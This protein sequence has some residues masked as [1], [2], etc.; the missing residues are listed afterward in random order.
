MLNVEKFFEL[1]TMTW[2]QMYLQFQVGLLKQSDIYL[3]RM[4]RV[5]RWIEIREIRW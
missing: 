5:K 1:L 3:K 4:K 2:K